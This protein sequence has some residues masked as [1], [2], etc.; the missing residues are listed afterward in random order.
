MILLNQID[1]KTNKCLR[2]FDASR[3]KNEAKFCVIKK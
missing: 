1:I 2:K 3:L